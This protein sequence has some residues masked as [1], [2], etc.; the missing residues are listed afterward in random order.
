MYGLIV[1]RILTGLPRFR[2]SQLPT[3]T[4]ATLIV[5]VGNIDGWGCGICNVDRGSWDVGCGI[6]D[7]GLQRAMWDMQCSGKDLS[8]ATLR[9]LICVVSIGQPEWT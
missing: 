3:A 8:N 7:V 9:F 1:V 6:W 2:R 5:R 4:A